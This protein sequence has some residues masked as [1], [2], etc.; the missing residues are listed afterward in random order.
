[1]NKAAVFFYYSNSGLMCS[2]D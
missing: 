1:M 2:V